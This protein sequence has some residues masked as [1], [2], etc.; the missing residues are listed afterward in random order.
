MEISKTKVSVVSFFQPVAAI[1]INGWTKQSMLEHIK[2]NFK[3][4]SINTK[5]DGEDI[6]LYRGP[7]GKKCAVGLFI[8]DEKY[9]RSMEE[10]S[11]L[12]DVLRCVTQHFPLNPENMRVLQYIHDTSKEENCL[13]QMI[14]WVEQNVIDE[15]A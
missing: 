12:S 11:P 13:S 3:G 5:S 9:D 4:K 10:C 7:D 1:T 14:E 8:P 6:C 2:T 15:V